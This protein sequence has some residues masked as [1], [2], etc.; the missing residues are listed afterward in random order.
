MHTDLADIVAHPSTDAIAMFEQELRREA[1]HCQHLP[2]EIRLSDA[3]ACGGIRYGVSE[4]DRKSVLRGIADALELSPHSPGRSR[5]RP[6]VATE[7]TGFNATGEVIALPHPGYAFLSASPRPAA[8]LLLLEEQMGIAGPDGLW[9]DTVF[10][11]LSPTRE[12]H[13]RLLSQV[14]ALLRDDDVRL[15]LRDRAPAES[16]LDSIRRAERKAFDLS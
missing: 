1:K 5:L 10:V 8:L 14:A 3:I 13:V 12:C 4:S 11:I 16:L 2:A 7:L 6:L 15:N 9:I